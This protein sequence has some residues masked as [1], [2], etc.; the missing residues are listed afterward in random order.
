MIIRK[1]IDIPY[2]DLF[3][4]ILNMFSSLFVNNLYNFKSNEL[5]VT[6]VTSG[7]H[8]IL[9]T[10]NLPY[11][12][13]VL[14]TGIN[15][16]DVE[17]IIK[18]H[19]LV[20]VPYDIDFK[21][22]KP[23]NDLSTLITSK[24]KIIFITQLFG[25]YIDYNEFINFDDIDS[26]IYIIEDLSQAYPHK[27]TINS[28][29]QMYDFGLIK[30]MTSVSGSSI[31][32]KDLKLKN[33]VNKLLSTYS[34]ESNFSFLIKII[35]C[36]F[37]K[38]MEQKII[39]SFTI[40]M[41]IFFNIDYD[42]LVLKFTKN[43]KYNN[44][45]EFIS[46]LEKQISHSNKYLLNKRLNI[47]NKD[48]LNINIGNKKILGN[49]IVDKIKNISE[50]NCPEVNNNTFWVFPIFINENR[51]TI[52]KKMRLLGYDLTSEGSE[53]KAINNNN[54]ITKDNCDNFL[55]NSIYLPL[56]GS[57]KNTI[58]M[59]NDLIKIINTTNNYTLFESVKDVTR[60][61]FFGFIF[62]FCIWNYLSYLSI[63]GSILYF[64]F[65]PSDIKFNFN[66]ME[67]KLTI[68]SISKTKKQFLITGVT[69]FL[70]ETLVKHI[71]STFNNEDIEIN[72]LIRD[73]KGISAKDRCKKMFGDTVN[74]VTLDTINNINSLTHVIHS[75]ADVGFNSSH[76]YIAETNI[77]YTL[78]MKEI[79]NK[80]NAKF[81]Y[82][83]T[84][85]VNSNNK[86]TNNILSINKRAIDN[87]FK[88]YN[89]MLNESNE[90]SLL[91]KNEGIENN[92]VLSKIISEN[93]IGNDSVI[94]RPSIITPAYSFMSGWGGNNFST[95]TAIVSA[96]ASKL[97]RNSVK[98]DINSNK[99]API[100]PVDFVTKRIIEKLDEK[101]GTIHLAALNTN[102]S[103]KFYNW[104]NAINK[105]YDYLYSIERLSSLEIVFLKVLNFIS[106]M[107]KS[108]FYLSSYLFDYIWVPLRYKNKINLV[109]KYKFF[110]ETNFEVIDGI[111]L[112]SRFNNL[113][114]VKIICDSSLNFIKLPI[115]E[116]RQNIPFKMTF[117]FF[118]CII[119]KIFSYIL[120][121]TTNNVTVNVSKLEKLS[122]K[123]N[124]LF[125]PSHRSFL[126]FMIICK[127]C[128]KYSSY[129]LK[130]PISFA[131]HKF[132]NSFLISK[133]M[134]LTNT[135][136]IDDVNLKS[137]IE[138]RSKNNNSYQLFLEGTRSRRR[139][140]LEPH[141]GILGY[142]LENM[143]L[144]IVPVTIN[145]E[146]IPDDFKTTITSGGLLNWIFNL[147]NI[148]LGDINVQIGDIIEVKQNKFNKEHLNDLAIQ[149]QN[150]QKKMV[151]ITEYHLQ[152]QNTK[153]IELMNELRENGCIVKKTTLYKKEDLDQQYILANQFYHFLNKDHELVKQ[154]DEYNKRNKI[155][156][157]NNI[158]NLIPMD[159]NTLLGYW[160]YNDTYFSIRNNRAFLNGSRYNVSNKY[161]NIL[162]FFSNYTNL[163]VLTKVKHF[164][165]ITRK[166]DSL[167]ENIRILTALFDSNN[168]IYSIDIHNRLRHGTGHAIN[169][170]IL[171]RSE[172]LQDYRF[173]D[174]IVYA[175]NM[176]EV[177]WIVNKAKRNNYCIVPFGGGTNVSNALTC[178]KNEDRIIISLDMSKMNNIVEI[179]RDNMTAQ[180]EA[181]ITGKELELK[182]N[183]SG[184]TCGMAPDSYEFSTLGGWIATYSSGMKRAKYG[185]IEE[186]V[187]GMNVI[188]SNGLI[189][190]KMPYGRVSHGIKIHNNFFGSEGNLG[191]IV[192]AVVRIHKLPEKVVFDSAIFPDWN[193]GIKAV[194]KMRLVKN[195]PV[196]I[197]L[198]DNTQFRL[199]Q[200]MKEKKSNFFA[201]M[202]LKF[203]GIDKN[204]IVAMTLMYEGSD[205]EINEQKKEINKIIKEYKGIIGGKTNGESGYNL[206]FA[207]AYLRDFLLEN[208]GIVSESFETFIPWDKLS[209]LEANLSPIIIKE[210]KN[211][212]LD[213]VPFI[214]YRI[215]QI[216]NEGVCL[217]LYYGFVSNKLDEK[218][219]RDFEEMSS[220]IKNYII[221]NGG[222]ISHHHGIGKLKFK[223]FNNNTANE[224]VALTKN[225]VNTFDPDNIFAIN[226]CL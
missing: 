33:K 85:F 68:D 222:S 187:M 37:L 25:S 77:T 67:K 23:T 111:T 10:L 162:D 154:I 79:A 80:Y 119:N 26:N 143:D 61:I 41:F 9:S 108:C 118:E 199:G 212:N 191:V 207:I 110:T 76:S 200:S 36:F 105:I 123:K 101:E 28:H 226:N 132:K 153:K 90:I 50:I 11:G 8:T 147:K 165:V 49:L 201:E 32:F 180:V 221:N 209:S 86:N 173:P 203:K 18:I 54:D 99:P 168:F 60:K 102:S 124:I 98:L 35:K 208:F 204:K 149:I 75:A 45:N 89:D 176:N 206:T 12:S 178:N 179:N 182:L 14:I 128:V 73:K 95:V 112:P 58:K 144:T 88:I 97:L 158:R 15:I 218:C 152:I 127:I 65:R 113:L 195:K 148:V 181:G 64:V 161:H 6:S 3:L 217:Y 82:V 39:F 189:D 117:S 21:T 74:C 20:P 121:K 140:F 114:Y 30:R 136:F 47:D 151:N 156:P 56:T 169:D 52:I 106:K 223:E 81:I 29:I 193:E 43:M 183:K 192:S 188:T 155:E 122:D 160:G 17:K 184:Y 24:T 107:S 109:Y 125:V 224:V 138:K 166:Q 142:L 150:A 146:K 53:L 134:S 22:L 83:S 202:Y 69:G 198:V 185:N 93:L 72:V 175:K 211:K 167:N 103:N 157:I 120:N 171:L 7:L 130:F 63:I 126:D 139:D 135:I 214:S 220:I 137:I 48:I 172:D 55:K 194:K 177:L 51:N 213:E 13:E 34:T 92:Y 133:I 131:T 62:S 225:L 27:S 129:G 100:I 59:A 5:V 163:N 186:I 215:S 2:Y 104:N 31:I 94:I 116:L 84:A 219:K 71:I 4:T 66:K 210:H 44:N 190:Y 164:P 170:M 78:K 38:I 96:I 141:V 145:Y 40:G 115:S 19:G 196:S 70:G 159:N 42:K 205:Y 174:I 216:Y 197:R 91:M 57:K 1:K 16:L 87:P 46:L